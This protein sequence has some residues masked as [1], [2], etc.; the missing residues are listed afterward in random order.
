MSTS[1]RIIWTRTRTN[2]HPLS[3]LLMTSTYAKMFIYCLTCRHQKHKQYIK[4][5]KHCHLPD[6][7]FKSL[8]AVMSWMKNTKNK[9]RFA[10]SSF[11]SCNKECGSF[12]KYVYPREPRHQVYP[13]ASQTY[14]IQYCTWSSLTYKPFSPFLSYAPWSSAF[15]VASVVSLSHFDYGVYWHRSYRKEFSKKYM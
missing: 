5:H 10:T 15:I 6:Y 3:V 8:T 9:K 14:I 12:L 1:R 11:N 13:Q 4:Y 7:N 2:D